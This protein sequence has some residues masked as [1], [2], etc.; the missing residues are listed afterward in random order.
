MSN[1]SKLPAKPPAKPEVMTS[2]EVAALFRVDT[3][4]VSRWAKAGR[5]SW[6]R[7]LGIKPGSVG[8]LRFYRAEVEALL[9]GDKPSGGAR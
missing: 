4:T 8:H 9:R 2:G 7:T 6:F 3:K 1:A 5:L